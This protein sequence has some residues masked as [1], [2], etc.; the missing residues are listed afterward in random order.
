MQ[1]LPLNARRIMNRCDSLAR[2]TEDSGKLT[3]IF[4]TREH[5][6]AA[7]EVLGWM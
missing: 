4:L 3:R 1:A 2:H 5:R 6:A 7:D